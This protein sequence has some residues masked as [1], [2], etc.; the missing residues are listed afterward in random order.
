MTNPSNFHFAGCD[1]VELAKQFGTPL[2]VVSE[3]I[4]N[5]KCQ[6]IRELFLNKYP[7]TKVAYASKAFLT[8]AMCKIIDREGLGLD[9]VSGGELYTAINADFPME[10]VMFH[11]N[12]KSYEELVLAVDNNVGRIIVDNFFELDMLASIAKD[13]DKIVSI[14]FRVAPGIGGKTHEYIS[15]G[16]TDSKFG[17]C[18]EG[19]MV[20][21]AV[22]QAVASPNI[23]LKGFHFHVGSQL[24]DIHGYLSSIQVV[25]RIMRELKSTLGFVAEELN[26]GGGFGINYTDGDE[27]TKPLS[28]FVDPIMAN[29]KTGCEIV[30]IDM[31]TIIIEPGR[32]VVGEAGI[33]LYTVGAI[34]EIPEVRTYASID[35]GFPDNPR[36]ALYKS[37][38]HG[39]LANKADKVADKTVTIAG[40]CCETGDILIWDLQVPQIESGDT[41]AVLKTGAYN[42]SMA[43]NYNR[44]PRPAVVLLSGGKPQVIVERECYQDLIAREIIPSSL[45]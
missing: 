21:M 29:I 12:N 8:L 17:I 45:R 19:N 5:V 11:G 18:L 24:F 10:K 34:K 32:W 41:L 42:Y 6:Q 44:L 26:I 23:D 39:I 37:K 16:Q 14:L 43:S 15:T 2:Y 7:N 25:L 9:V 13:R 35:G 36:P 40:K 33:T 22:K 31:P 27:E 4:I 38:Y 1:T 30:G 28:F 20:Q 3:D